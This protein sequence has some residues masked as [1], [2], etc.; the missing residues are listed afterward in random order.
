M[1]V[2]IIADISWLTHGQYPIQVQ[3]DVEC[4][5]V[6]QDPDVVE[7]DVIEPPSSCASESS[8]IQTDGHLSSPRTHGRVHKHRLPPTHP[9]LSHGISY[10]PFLHVMVEDFLQSTQVIVF[11]FSG[12]SLILDMSDHSESVVVGQTLLKRPSVTNDSAGEQK[13]D[14]KDDSSYKSR[15]RLGYDSSRQFISRTTANQSNFSSSCI[16]SIVSQCFCL[17]LIGFA[18]RVI[19][20]FC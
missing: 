3:E 16:K 5:L 13:F 10:D 9:Q 4:P 17:L 7:S 18:R 8:Y 19:I 11:L 14:K 2:L 1:I 15:I 12:D 6:S 20:S